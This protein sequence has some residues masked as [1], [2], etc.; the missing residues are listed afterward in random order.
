MWGSA[1]SDDSGRFQLC[2]QSPKPSYSGIVEIK[3]VAVSPAGE[4]LAAYAPDQV[5]FI[6]KAASCTE[7]SKVC[8]PATAPAAPAVAAAVGMRSDGVN[9]AAP[10]AGAA[11]G[12]TAGSAGSATTEPSTAHAHNSG[13]AVVRAHSQLG[14]PTLALLSAAAIRLRQRARSRRAQAMR[15]G[16]A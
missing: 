14:W 10:A 8:C 1:P 2:F 3:V 12:P 7:S 16:N 11:A 15:R 5:V 13:C 6:P 9:A 4:Q